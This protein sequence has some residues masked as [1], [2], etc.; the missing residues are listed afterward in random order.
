MQSSRLFEIVYLLVG[1]SQTGQPMLKARELAE[2]FEVSER[3]IYRDIDTLSAAGIPVYT[4]KGRE[5]GISLLDG[6][7]LDRSLLSASEKADIL[8]SLQAMR[9]TR[10]SSDGEILQ[11]LSTLFAGDRYDWIRIDFAPWGSEADAQKNLDLIKTSILQKH[12][13]RFDYVSAQ[14]GHTRRTVEPL[15]MRFKLR[16]WYLFAWDT[17][18]KDFRLFRISRLSSP[19]M[20]EEAFERRIPACPPPEQSASIHPV[21]L[22]L[23]FAP[24]AFHRLLDDVHRECIHPQED[25]S[26]LVDITFPEDEW[27]YGYLLS[28]GA[29]VEVLS[30]PHIRDILCQRARAILQMYKKYDTPCPVSDAI[31]GSSHNKRWTEKMEKFC[32]CC[33]MPL[34][35]ENRAAEKDGTPNGDYCRYCYA[36][37]KIQFNGTMEEMI[38]FCVPIC[39][40]EGVYPDDNTAREAMQKFFPLLK[41]WKNA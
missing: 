33:G 11:K 35:D 1:R 40:R 7:V 23:R 22:R 8:A 15:Q 39:V 4:Q 41:H 10:L 38:E 27:V 18:R 37:G 16:T 32:Q 3:T 30:P 21:A 25:G 34:N 13:L 28:F 19:E 6:F 29:D 20:L 31:L 14:G 36:D 9:S 12:R 17:G 2:R 5:G 24:R 26:Y